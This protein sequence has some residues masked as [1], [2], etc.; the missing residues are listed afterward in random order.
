MKFTIIKNVYRHPNG[1]YIHG[2]MVKPHDSEAKELLKKIHNKKYRLEPAYRNSITV[3][4][5]WSVGLYWTYIENVQD[6]IKDIYHY[7]LFT[8]EVE[9]SPLI[10]VIK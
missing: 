6:A 2:A 5:W 3:D 4:G 9:H 8:K 1:E 10:K 7:F